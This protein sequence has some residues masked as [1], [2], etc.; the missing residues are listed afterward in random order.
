MGK[1]LIMSELQNVIDSIVKNIKNHPERMRFSHDLKLAK[2]HPK[3]ELAYFNELKYDLYKKLNEDN[4]IGHNWIDND[5]PDP[6]KI[7]E[8][9]GMIWIEAFVDTWLQWE[10]IQHI[11]ENGLLVELKNEN[12][13][14]IEDVK[15]ELL[16]KNKRQYKSQIESF[17]QEYFYIEM[18][19]KHLV[20]LNGNSEKNNQSIPKPKH[21]KNPP[22]KKFID[23]FSDE[24]NGKKIDKEKLLEKLKSDFY[25]YAGQDLRFLIEALKE[26]DVLRIIRGK[27]N[28]FY[29][30]MDESLN[31]NIG[32]RNSVVYISGF[33]NCWEPG[34]Q[35]WLDKEYPK[36]NVSPHHAKYTE[37]K[38]QVESIFELEDIKI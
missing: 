19:N 12:Y 11:T 36:K 32:A 7:R 2:I 28:V 13:Q 31:W 30:A 9:T 4:T 18:I 24:Y 5:S 23:Y 16:D 10:C 14:I 38:K 3:G 22:A 34:F 26:L 15:K 17:L 1:E 20:T 6:L 25:G 21:K 29:K 33:P 8:E 35:E 27:G 37:I